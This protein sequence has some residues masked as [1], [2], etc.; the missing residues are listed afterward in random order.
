MESVN[1]AHSFAALLLSAEYMKQA[2]RLITSL[3]HRFPPM[4]A[5]VSLAKLHGVK[6]VNAGAKFCRLMTSPS[7]W[8]LVKRSP[9]SKSILPILET[10]CHKMAS[11]MRE[12]HNLTLL[13]VGGTAA[14]WS[15][16]SSQ[17]KHAYR[18]SH[19]PA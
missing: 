1:P 18:K 7:E 2:S 11:S 13:S 3:F 16:H 4:M 15:P 14:L 10:F 19:Q 12:E 6:L 5:D 9:N 17:S 8:E